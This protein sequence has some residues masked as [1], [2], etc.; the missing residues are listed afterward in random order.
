MPDAPLIIVLNAGSGHDDKD[1][2]ES[3]IRAVLDA[4]GRTYEIVSPEPGAIATTLA[5]RVARTGRTGVLVAA[6]GDGTLNAVAGAALDA[7]W[8]LGIVPLGTFNFY[9]RD[10]GI[11]LE[12]GAATQV[13]VDGT[14]RAVAVGR[15]N[16]H[17]FLNNASFGLYRQLLE[18]REEVKHRFGRYRLIAGIAALWTLWRH[19]RNYRLRLDIDGRV[20]KWRTPMVFFGLNALQLEKL[21]LQI[22]TCA[23]EDR[24]AILAPPP[25]PRWRLLWLALKG[26]AH[27]LE[28]GRDIVCRCATRVTMDWPGH[29][30]ARVA[31]DGESVECRLP[32]SVEVKPRALRVLVP[33]QPEVRE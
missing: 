14:T 17:L 12:A 3:A 9:A 8:A 29:H 1:Q 30:R 7:G 23:A 22:A 4:A 2:S 6:G 16:G 28:E 15:I 25:L 31:V 26:A 32:L 5:E 18:D 11:P 13:L 21:A 33:R 27:Q 24:L 10:L 20:E 19:R